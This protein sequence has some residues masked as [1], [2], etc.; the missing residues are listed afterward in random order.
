MAIRASHE[1]NS[2]PPAQRYLTLRSQG[3]SGA[4]AVGWLAVDAATTPTITDALRER[5]GD[6][7]AAGRAALAGVADPKT[8]AQVAAG[9]LPLSWALAGL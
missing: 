4:D 2:L 5:G 3:T 6:G 8:L 9:T 7:A 1:P